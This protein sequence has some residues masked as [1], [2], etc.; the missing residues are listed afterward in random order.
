MQIERDR[1]VM[2][3]AEGA[4]AVAGADNDDDIISGSLS[5]AGSPVRARDKSEALKGLKAYY[6]NRLGHI[7]STLRIWKLFGDAMGTDV[8][9]MYDGTFEAGS[10][11]FKQAKAVVYDAAFNRTKNVLNVIPSHKLLLSF[12]PKIKDM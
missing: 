12:L 9:P 3:S 5:R 6:S 2:D 8:L 7:I 4:V 10:L 1:A 11:G